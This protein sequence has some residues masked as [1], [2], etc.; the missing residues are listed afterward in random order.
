MRKRCPSYW[1]EFTIYLPNEAGSTPCFKTSPPA[2]QAHSPSHQVV[3]AQPQWLSHLVST[4]REPMVNLDL[5]NSVD[6]VD[7]DTLALHGCQSLLPPRELYLE[8]FRWQPISR[9]RSRDLE[10][11]QYGPL[12][13]GP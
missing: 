3:V 9:G 13:W 7:L 1:K 11:I 10:P 5:Q 6:P 4:L 8:E 2:I 12:E